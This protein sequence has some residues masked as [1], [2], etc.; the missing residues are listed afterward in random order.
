MGTTGNR[1]TA[2]VRPRPTRHDACARC[3]GLMVVAHCVDL[4][5]H[6]EVISEGLR[7]T[8]CGDFIDAM[9]L[10]NRLKPLP[11]S[12]DGPKKRKFARQVSHKRPA[13]GK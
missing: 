13:T 9:V 1:N 4:Q 12:L 2:L 10:A 11:Q 8:N 7:C 3:G 5:G 6:A